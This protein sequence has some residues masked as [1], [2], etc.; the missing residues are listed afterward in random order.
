MA[1][2]PLLKPRT[3]GAENKWGEIEKYSS[4]IHT[5]ILLTD[6]Y[7][8]FL[9]LGK[10]FITVSVERLRQNPYHMKKGHSF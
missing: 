2:N 10:I 1:R 7:A 4:L 5:V 8:K 6:L 9:N 3:G